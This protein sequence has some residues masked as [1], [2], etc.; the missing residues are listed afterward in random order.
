[1]YKAHLVGVYDH[2]ELPEELQGFVQLQAHRQ[3]YSPKKEDKV[4]VLQIIG[5]T[6]YFP[7]FIN[8]VETI[9]QIDEDLKE[10]EAILDD[11]SRL[12]MQRILQEKDL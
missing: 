4:A 9:E 2:G 8:R 1:L 11:V 7:I 10:A 3:K 6:S 5:T 12:S